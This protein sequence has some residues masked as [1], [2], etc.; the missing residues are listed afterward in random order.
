M[1]VKLV[2]IKGQKLSC[3]DSATFQ[4]SIVHRNVGEEEADPTLETAIEYAG[5]LGVIIFDKSCCLR[6]L[7][8]AQVGRNQ[9]TMDVAVNWLDERIDEV[10]RRADHA[11]KQLSTLEGKVTNMEE[12]Y[13]ELLALGWEQVETSAWS[14]WAL[15]SL[16]T[17][18]VAQQQKIL[19]VEERINVMRE[20]I[21]ALEH[22]QENPIMVEDGSDDE[23][24]VSNQV[25][26]KMEEN[27]V[28][29]LI[30][31][32]GWLVPIEDMVQVLLDELVGT[33]ITF[34]LADEDC[35]PSY[36]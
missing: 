27:K 12:G 33:Q 35:P 20:M 16:A 25:E 3:P 29:I 14:C 30:P 34:D 7:T 9:F 6:D 31:P 2:E 1:R 26:L 11:S 13:R 18:V 19:Q 22:T 17:V 4:H 15:V 21:L 23:M 36:E 5:A 10:D 8:E 24:A 32:P 28:A